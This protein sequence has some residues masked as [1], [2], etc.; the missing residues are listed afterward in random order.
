MLELPYNRN[1]GK[2][3]INDIIRAIRKYKLIT[4]NEKI[5]VA[6]SG[7]KDSTLLLYILKYIQKYSDLSFIF[8]AVHIK[9]AE[10]DTSEL[11]SFCT[12]LGV[13]Y[14]EQSLDFNYNKT[15]ENCYICSR[16][17]RGALAS[18]L[19]SLGIHKIAYGHHATDIAET[20]LMNIIKNKR[21]NSLTPRVEINDSDMTI[22]RPMIYL[23]EI[24]ISK[25]FKTLELPTF[26][27][28][29]PYQSTTNRDRYK[30]MIKRIN[31]VEGTKSFER[32]LVET[33][34]RSDLPDWSSM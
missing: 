8:T 27:I 6:V 21:I 9:I 11:A 33:L 30:A 15:L 31:Q 7:G 16:L 23:E 5:A 12:S 3:F 20:F 22:I 17:K 25:I 1:Y 10:Y 19:P 2:W 28:S 24:R 4:D 29:C 13:Q 14:H 26:D 34:E 32:R 18:F